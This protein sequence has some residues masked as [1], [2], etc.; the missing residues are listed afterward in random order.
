MNSQEM[1]LKQQKEELK[2]REDELNDLK[3]GFDKI[4]EYAKLQE[5][6]LAPEEKKKY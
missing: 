5:K 4:I 6:R 2:N 3:N 1:F